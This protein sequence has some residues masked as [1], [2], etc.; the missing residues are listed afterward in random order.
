MKKLLGFFSALIILTMACVVPGL[1]TDASQPLPTADTRLENMIPLTVSAALEQTQQAQ[2]TQTLV[3]TQ[4]AVPTATSTPEADSAGSIL[5][6][7]DDDSFLFTDELGKYQIA[8]PKELMALRINQQEFLDA[9]LLPVASN[10]A[11]QNQLD[12]IQKQDPN[13]FRLFAF[14]FNE[15]HI[16]S[17]FVTNVNFL[18]DDATNLSTEEQLL[19]ATNQYL[20]AFPG[21]EIIETKSVVLQNQTLVGLVKFKNPV[22]TLE[23][24][25]INVIQK[26]AF[27]LLPKG[28]LAITLSTAES[29]IEFVEPLFDAM[30]ET[31][32][33]VDGIEIN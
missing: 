15:E 29:Q 1:S 23:G 17:G 14:D 21:A 33:L 20:Q 30:L 8:I 5:V 3:P 28:V 18:W 13:R 24:D 19:A 32:S 7:N 31:F 6:K 27:L 22:T 12:L 4:T 26:Q 11:I 2:P 25:V 16:A 10:P 9:W